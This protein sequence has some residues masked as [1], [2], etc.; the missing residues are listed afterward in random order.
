MKKFTNI[1][2]ALTLVFSLSG[3][4]FYIG[5]SSN[6]DPKDFLENPQKEFE[7]YDDNI[8]NWPDNEPDIVDDI[9][10]EYDSALT[11]PDYSSP[12]DEI[13]I[14]PKTEEDKKENVS[15][16]EEKDPVVKYNDLEIH[17]IDVGQADCILMIDSDE[18]LMIDAGNNDDSKTITEY[19]NNLNIDTIDYFIL[20]HPHED[21]IGSA[22][23][24]IN[25][26]TVENLYMTEY[27]A[28]TK[29]YKDVIKAINNNA[30]VP[31][32]VDDIIEFE[33]GDADVTLYPPYDIETKETNNSSIIT[34]VKHGEDTMLFAG[35]T[36]SDAEK[37]L[38]TMDYDLTA[39]LFKANHHGSGGAN[40]Y[41]WLKEVNP[42][43]VVI[44]AGQ[45]NKYGHPH[46]EALSRFNDVG[47]YI[48][49]TDMMGTIIVHSSGNGFNF[50]CEG[51]APTREHTN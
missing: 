37:E 38:L 48:W 20:T 42:Q 39:D 49:R 8:K 25:N 9:W 47:A 36:E 51:I 35:D 30:M 17:F 22:D 2:I 44:Q 5:P 27:T 34:H 13:Y 18:V 7:Y 10:K 14:P 33:F 19:L 4:S 1:L 21:H 16:N 23:T 50:S 28:T 29:T 31:T 3:C 26:F 40:S 46:E 15:N 41:V 12:E 11:K 45:D 6:Q 24:V 32:Y 43:Y